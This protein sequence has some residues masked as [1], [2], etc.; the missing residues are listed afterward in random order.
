[1]HLRWRLGK[2]VGHGGN[3]KQGILIASG[4]HPVLMLQ[5]GEDESED[6]GDT[7]TY[8]DQGDHLPPQAQWPSEVPHR[9]TSA[10]KL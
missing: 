1:M 9:V 7:E 8:E 4:Y 2:E 5:A 6:L 3:T 10:V